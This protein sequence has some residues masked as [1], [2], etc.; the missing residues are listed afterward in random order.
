MADADPL[1]VFDRAVSA[2]R[3]DLV[4]DAPST[5]HPLGTTHALHVVRLRLRG[6]E[7][8]F[9][10]MPAGVE[11]VVGFRA[12]VDADAVVVVTSIVADM[13]E[14]VRDPFDITRWVVRRG[15]AHHAMGLVSWLFPL[16][17][18]LER[19]SDGDPVVDVVVVTEI[20]VDAGAL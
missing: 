8:S 4:E 1:L 7:V 5:S 6:R 14:R 20:A 12:F 3:L 11:R 9:R 10:V 13:R 15:Y 17:V 16:E 18:T 2:A 19:R